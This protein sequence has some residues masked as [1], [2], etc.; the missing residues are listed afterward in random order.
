MREISCVISLTKPLA[1]GDYVAFI[2][3]YG[4]KFRE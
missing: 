2:N 1:Y 3:G 4:D